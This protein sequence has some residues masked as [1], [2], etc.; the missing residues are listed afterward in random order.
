MKPLTTVDKAKIPADLQG[1]WILVW[2]GDCGFCRR[3]V[4][5]ALARDKERKLVAKPYQGCQDW[6]PPKVWALSREQFHLISP[7]GVVWGNGAAASRLL[8]LIGL[9]SVSAALELPV[10]SFLT[11]VGYR[12][13]AKNRRLFSRLFFRPSHSRPPHK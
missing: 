9:S 10:L 12:V 3:S 4:E 7:Q 11:S 2:D 5:W 8:D 1:K 6:L 13:V